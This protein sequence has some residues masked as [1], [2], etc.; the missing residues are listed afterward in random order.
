MKKRTKGRKEERRGGRGRDE[1]R[2]KKEI[3]IKVIF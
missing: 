3:E 2:E 1:E